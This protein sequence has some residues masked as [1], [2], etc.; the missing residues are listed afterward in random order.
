MTEVLRR[1][2]SSPPVAP[3]KVDPVIDLVPAAGLLWMVEARP[4][5]I[6]KDATLGPA[7]ATI[8]PGWRF[9]VFA[10][11][12]GGIDLRAAEE[13]V[14]GAYPQATLALARVGFDPARVTAAFG[15]RVLRVE[16]RAVERGG[17]TR[18]WGSISG[19]RE[20]VALLA[21]DAVV[22][23]RG[24][25]GPLQA[26]VYFAQG[27]LKRSLPVLRAEPLVTAAALAG[28]APLRM[29]APGPFQGDWARGLAGLLRATTAVAASLRPMPNG[30]I[31][32]RVLLMGGW[33]EDASAAAERLRSAYGILAEDP[34]GQLTGM[35]R[36][37]DGPSVSADAAALTLEVTLEAAVL[38]RGLHVATGASLEEIMAY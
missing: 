22:F 3:L 37:V 30:A 2:A 6:L 34:L 26:A 14:I 17:V 31:G 4:R 9:D 28:D 24:Q 13:L 15:T 35:D 32:L 29:F 16:G 25:L 10:Q 7:V 38:G 23:E 18:I 21:R 19:G 11:H 36:P 27:R 8:I 33:G 12:H 1:D 5:E 20:Q